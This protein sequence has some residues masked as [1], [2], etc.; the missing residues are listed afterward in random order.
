MVPQGTSGS[1]FLRTCVWGGGGKIFS[2]FPSDVLC[3]LI[4]PGA[5]ASPP[6]QRLFQ[7]VQIVGNRAKEPDLTLGAGWRDGNGNGVFVDIQAEIEFSSLHGVVVSSH[8]HDESERRP[9]RVR[10][11]SCGSAHPGNP[12]S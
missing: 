2:S 4:E 1:S 11:R 12:R 9:R 10:R 6:G 3:E 5:A 7:R 8:S